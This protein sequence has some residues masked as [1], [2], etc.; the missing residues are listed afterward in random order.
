MSNS[1][2]LNR[3]RGGALNL[4]CGFPIGYY[5]T[6]AKFSKKM[7][8]ETFLC[9]FTDFKCSKLRLKYPSTDIWA[10]R[11]R[12]PIQWQQCVVKEVG[13]VVMCVLNVNV[14]KDKGMSRVDLRGIPKATTTKVLLSF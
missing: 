1:T 4:M 3:R 14:V 8:E 5:D 6:Q 11:Q 12:H 2:N 10:C 7:K 13:K 9:L